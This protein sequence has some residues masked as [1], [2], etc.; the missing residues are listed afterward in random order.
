M[1]MAKAQDT[2]SKPEINIAD[3]K[4][5]LEMKQRELDLRRELAAMTNSTRQNQSQTQAAAKL[6]TTAMTS[7]SRAGGPPQQ[8]PGPVNIDNL[9]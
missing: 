4:S 3:I 2:A 7:A 6:A 5:K 8:M 1:N 9:N